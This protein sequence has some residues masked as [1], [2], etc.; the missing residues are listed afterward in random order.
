VG[1]IGN[2]AFENQAYNIISPSTPVE[3]AA[4]YDEA[5]SV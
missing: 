3:D 5:G 1:T 4:E 2:D